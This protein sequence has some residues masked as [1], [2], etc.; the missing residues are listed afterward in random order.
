MIYALHPGTY[1]IIAQ[2]MT[3]PII[4]LATAFNV[5]CVS[6]LKLLVQVSRM[7]MKER[8]SL[9]QSS[10]VGCKGGHDRASSGVRN[11]KKSA[12]EW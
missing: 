8:F 4:N 3:H 6:V 11:G 5:I 2:L 10:C 12:E 9:E 7:R 1:Q